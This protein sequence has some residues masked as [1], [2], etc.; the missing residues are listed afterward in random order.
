QIEFRGAVTA[1]FEFLGC[2]VGQ[3]LP[4]F[5]GADRFQA[6]CRRRAGN[7]GQDDPGGERKNQSRCDFESDATK[8]LHYAHRSALWNPEPN[9]A[10]P[11]A[12]PQSSIYRDLRRR[13]SF[14]AITCRRSSRVS[15]SSTPFL[16]G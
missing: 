7:A 11:P 1:S 3:L 13:S 2:K 14:H 4:Q 9:G 12:Y 8:V 15:L 10:L 5:I 16:Q 6:G